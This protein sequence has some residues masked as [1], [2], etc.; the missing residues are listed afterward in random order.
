MLVALRLPLTLAWLLL[1]MMH[2]EVDDDDDDA[3]DI[4]GVD[5][6]VCE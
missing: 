6:D 1:R 5:K 4:D 2:A 3:V